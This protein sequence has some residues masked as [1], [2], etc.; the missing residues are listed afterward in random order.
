MTAYIDSFNSAVTC[1]DVRAL[2]DD[3]T[4]CEYIKHSCSMR[5]TTEEIIITKPHTHN[6][7]NASHTL[8]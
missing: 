1:A 2:D 4:T 5:P 6:S 3:K 8:R 7:R